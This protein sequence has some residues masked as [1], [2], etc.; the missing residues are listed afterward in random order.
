[1]EIN[2]T[3][4][5][6][7]AKIAKALCMAQSKLETVKRST[8]AYNYKYADLASVIEAG[9]KVMTENGLSISQLMEPDTDKA[10]VITLLMHESGEWIKSTV[11]LKPTANTPQAMGS[12]ITYARRYG[13]QAILG[14][15][16]EEDDDGK[17]ASE[18][19]KKDAYVEP[20]FVCK[21][22]NK[23]MFKR[24]DGKIDHRMRMNEKK[25]YDPKG[26][27]YWCQG[28]DWHLSAKQ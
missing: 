8:Q 5:D 7:I 2:K 19:E 10:I 18:V 16:A 14:I 12:A 6:S 26:D 24:D 13:Y 27:W 28:H 11:A 9:K 22:H 4:S 23:E 17:N 15:A 20:E 1:M 3:M 25:E 21:V